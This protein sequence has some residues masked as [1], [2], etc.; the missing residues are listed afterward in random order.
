MHMFEVGTG[1]CVDSLANLFSISAACYSDN[2]AYLIMGS[3]NGHIGIWSLG[4]GFTQNITDVLD[5][6]RV[7]PKFWNDYPIM[8]PEFGKP[9]LED[10]SDSEITIDQENPQTHLSEYPAPTDSNGP[11]KHPYLRVGDKVM[12]ISSNPRNKKNDRARDGVGYA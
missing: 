3:K 10:S 7:N 4:T 11:K 2:G 12:S 9:D 5:Q 6:M 8:T 1:S